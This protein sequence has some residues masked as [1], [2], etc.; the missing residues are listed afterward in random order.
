M[1]RYAR[2]PATGDSRTLPILSSEHIQVH[3]YS[4]A[5]DPLR[6]P[7]L[8]FLPDIPVYN[9]GFLTNRSPKQR[10]YQKL[11]KD[12]WNSRTAAQYAVETLGSS[13]DEDL[14]AD[15]FLRLKQKTQGKPEHRYKDPA[16]ELMQAIQK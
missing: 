16:N 7:G 4:S 14:T 1:R 15:E 5:C 11:P 3:R 8:R 6:E 10:D 12:T 2:A 9:Q 13:D